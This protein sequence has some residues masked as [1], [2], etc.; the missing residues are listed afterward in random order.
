[1]NISDWPLEKI[2]QL[3]DHCFGRRYAVSCTID[4]LGE[5]NYFD[6]SEISFPE[7]FVLWEM[8]FISAGALNT[9]IPIRL[10]MG[11]QIPAD[12]AAMSLLEPFIPGL[13]VQGREPRVMQLSPTSGSGI[14]MFRQPI[15][16]SGRRLIL[17][18]QGLSE[19][20]YLITVVA[21]IS[22]IPK[23]IPDCL[24]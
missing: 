13:G 16:A 10:A 9:I 3:P 21:I 22:S 19:L 1:M 15:H 23:D 5:A 6:I 14:R 2:M 18:V 20:Q 8:S 4:E 12:T 17:E 11:D 7:T 24:I